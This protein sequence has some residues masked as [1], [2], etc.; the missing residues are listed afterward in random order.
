[1]SQQL[2]QLHESGRGD[3]ARCHRGSA[4]DRAYHR[5]NHCTAWKMQAE[6]RVGSVPRIERQGRSA[7]YR[8]SSLTSRCISKL[9]VEVCLQR[10]HQLFLVPCVSL[11]DFGAGKAFS[12]N[13]TS[14]LMHQML[15]EEFLEEF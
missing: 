3:A 1:M 10:T 6:R 11:P 13:D 7:I 12:V 9:H 5:Q 14:R 15:L 2:R 4:S 8:V